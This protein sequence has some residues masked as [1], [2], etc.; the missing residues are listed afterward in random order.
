M[1]ASFTLKD[2][3]AVNTKLTKIA[4]ST[5]AFET[6]LTL[7]ATITITDSFDKKIIAT[8]D[9]DNSGTEFFIYNVPTKLQ[10]KTISKG[11]ELNVYFLN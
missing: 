2:D 5:E 4:I 7:P 8:L 3:Y 11:S 9:T 10:T 1:K 6:G